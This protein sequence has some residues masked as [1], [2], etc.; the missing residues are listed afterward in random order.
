MG[1]LQQA[2]QQANETLYK[3]NFE[4]SVKNQTLS[5]LR[6]LYDVSLTTADVTSTSQKIADAIVQELGFAVVMISLL[7][8]NAKCLR[9]IAVSDSTEIREAMTKMGKTLDEINIP[10]DYENNLCITCIRNKSRQ[11]TTNLLDILDPAVTQEVADEVGNIA[12]IKTIIIYPLILGDEPIGVI[13]VGLAKKVDDLSRAEKETLEQLIGLV[14]LAV[15]RAKLYQD[16]KEANIRLKQLDQLKDEFISVTSHELRAPM[17]AIK[18]YTWLVLNSKEGVLEPK[19]REHLDKVY[20]STERLIHL[21]NEMLDVSRIESGRVQLH[22]ESFDMRQLAETV[23][24]EFAAK[25]SEQGTELEVTSFGEVPLVIADR[26][27][28]HQILENL[29]SNAIKFTQSGKITIHISQADQF[30]ETAVTDT[31]EGISED[32]QKK[33]FVKFGRLENSLIARSG[34]GSGLGLYICKQYVEL[35][36]GRIWFVSEAG[37]GSTFTFNLPLS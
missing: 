25:A 15:D 22:P 3:Q 2:V 4:L 19:A 28:V 5:I 29:V 16:L 12:N 26:E 18:S 8:K 11:M 37:K 24:D 6:R 35:H 10:S 30:V 9:P 14:T 27:K 32:D 33:L 1:D 21:V 23:K 13:N 31:G 7:D 34:T 36:H 17:T 20:Q